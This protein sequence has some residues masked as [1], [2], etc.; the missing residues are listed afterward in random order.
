VSCNLITTCPETLRAAAIDGAGIVLVPSFVIF[1]LLTSGAL[2]PLLRDYHA[3]EYEMVALYP[4]RRHLTA[5][6]RAFIDMLVDEF[7]Q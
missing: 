1:D 7:A 3:P 2:V 5:K 6:V 4:H